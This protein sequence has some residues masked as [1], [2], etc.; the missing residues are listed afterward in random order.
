MNGLSLGDTTSALTSHC[1]QTREI[2]LALQQRYLEFI[3]Q[4][5]AYRREK[6]AALAA[7]PTLRGSVR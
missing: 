7:S 2:L 6:S 5:E 4:A 1:Q 3:A